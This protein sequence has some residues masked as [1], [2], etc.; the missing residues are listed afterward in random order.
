MRSAAFVLLGALL[1]GIAGAASAAPALTTVAGASYPEGPL[2]YGDAL[3]FVEYAPGNLRRWDGHAST[4]VWHRDGCGPSAVA[5]FRGHLLVACYDDNSLVELDDAGHEVHVFRADRTGRPFHGPNDF[6]PD[7]RGGLYLSASGTYDLAA[8]I[9]GAVL[10][11]SADGSTLAELANTIH[12]PNGLALTRDGTTLLV[13]EMLAGRILSFPVAADGSLGARA[14]WARLQDLAPPTPG[15]D[16]YNGPDG[17]KL[18]PDGNYYVA[19][20]GSSRVLVVG[21]DRRLVRT[22]HVPTPY[23]TNI[24]F[25]PDG[26]VY[27]TGAFEQWKAP[28]AGAVY[29]WQPATRRPM[30]PGPAAPAVPQ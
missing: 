29:R 17:L 18:G 6:A 11:L 15:A 12:Y 22:I 20:N 30:N 23:V 4:V 5:P 21:T 2:W 3:L 16:G 1:T 8:P 14:V 10:H 9:T 26:S 13:A 25:G 19:Q 27:V 24:G 7:G 28:Y